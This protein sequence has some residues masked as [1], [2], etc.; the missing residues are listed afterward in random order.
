MLT[1]LAA[2]LADPESWSE[3]PPDLRNGV[4]D[5]VVS[6]R[7]NESPGISRLRWL[8]AAAAA[9]AVV[10]AVAAGAIALRS[11]DP[12]WEVPIAGTDLAPTAGG[13]VLGWNT[14]N[15]T[16][17]ALN[18]DGLDP[19]PEGFVY[20]FWLSAERQHISAGTFN[21]PAGVELWAGVS[22]RDF[23]RLWITLEPLDLNTSPSGHTVLDTDPPD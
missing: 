15:G 23:P 10:V 16:R 5:T 18:L 2:S 3:P 21:A 8:G 17:L 7:A 12:D 11:N 22:R 9:I 13:S 4:V 19:A 20:E 14:P 1:A 6:A